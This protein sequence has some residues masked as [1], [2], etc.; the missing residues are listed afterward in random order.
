MMLNPFYVLLAITAF[1]VIL[2]V[3]FFA[4]V[5]RERSVVVRRIRS[6]VA[7]SEAEDEAHMRSSEKVARK[8]SLIASAIR[9]RMGVETNASVEERFI[10][11][12]IRLPKVSDVYYVLR[13]LAPLILA[14]AGWVLSHKLLIG[15]AGVLVGYVA[16]SLFLDWL[17]RR[18]KTKLRRAMPD[19]V[20]MLVVC[21]DA[22]FGIEQA[23]LRT[24]REMSVAYPEVCYEL[25]ETNRQRQAGLTREQA[26]ESLVN[27]TKL[28]EI[29]TLVSMLNQADQL[30]TPLAV[31]LR[32]FS[33]SL[34]SQRSIAAEETAAR[35][36]VL[37]L[38]PL[39]LFIFPTVFIVIMGPAVLTLLNTL[40][41]GI[42]K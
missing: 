32:N 1:F 12:G 11:A 40:S 34:R 2:A 35:A 4:A 29:E 7:R 9:M 19:V 39:V 16:P 6:L 21:V 8:V 15:I 28:E 14:L 37:L 26:W 30:G 13:I 10:A 36:S 33:D 42:G 22:G 3:L 17:V 5:L 20:D 25:L 18:Y 27:R 24:A 38:I 31:G 23:L 41:Y